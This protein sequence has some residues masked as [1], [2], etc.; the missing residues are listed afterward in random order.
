MRFKNPS[1]FV[2]SCTL[3]IFVPLLLH[4][5]ESADSKLTTPIEKLEKTSLDIFSLDT[6]YTAGSNVRHAVV[7]GKEDVF[8]L[9]F[10]YSHRIHVNGNWYLRL[11][12]EYQLYDF[13]SAPFP[14]PDHLQGLSTEIAFEYVV[15]N[16]AA[17][18]ISVHPG[19]Y[20][21]NDITGKN[22]DI[23]INLYT[24]F[25]IKGDKLFGLVGVYE[26]QMLKPAVFP[27]GGIIWLI[28]DKV[29]LEAL[30][31]ESALIYS[32]NDDW[33][34]RTVAQAGGGGFRVDNDPNVPAVHRGSVVQYYYTEV[35]AQVKYSGW[36]PL[37]IS[38]GGGYD[39]DRKI[40][41][42]RDFPGTQVYN[43]TAAP[44][45]KVSI[46]AQF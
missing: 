6:S 44:Y 3:A 5:G 40:D 12:I 18:G 21:Q 42:F 23:P 16:F 27:V 34:F 19:F 46:G 36:K 26:R 37:T 10:E 30:F 28:N 15:K 8:S 33:E 1:K 17:T 39:L 13:G 31:P 20:F 45:V 25:K 38:I 2:L 35:G 11:G 22:F 24:S 32:L 14:L 7:I 4:G 9:D 29:R 41:F 43:L